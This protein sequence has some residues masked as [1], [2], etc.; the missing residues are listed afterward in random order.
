MK[1]CNDDF[2]FG[3]AW[4]AWAGPWGAK[5]GGRRKGGKSRIFDRGDLKY[6]VLRLLA[7][8]EMH[9]YEVMQALEEETGGWYTASPGSVYP[10]LQMLQDQD[11]VTSVEQDGKRVYRITDAG[12]AFLEENQDRADDVMDRVSDFASRFSGGGMGDVTRSFVK[13]AQASFE[14]AMK[15]SGDADAMRRIREILERAAKDMRGK[16]ATGANE[17]A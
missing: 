3:T 10:V 2:D 5:S 1:H 4:G 11:Y 16:K 12:R 15:E 8:K 7:R 13:L 17:T 6:A 14:E 9:G